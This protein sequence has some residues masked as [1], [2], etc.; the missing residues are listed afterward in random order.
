[1]YNTIIIGSGISGLFT[2]KHLLE[3]GIDNVLVLD[4]NPE[5]FG[6]WNRNNHPCVYETTYTVSSKLYMTIS[7][8]P[9]KDVAEFP[10]HSVIL[11]YYR[12]YAAHFNLYPYLHQNVTVQ[13]IY[14]NKTSWVVETHGN[15]YYCEHV[16]I[17]TGTVNDCPNIPTDDFYENFTGLKLHSDSFDEI[18]GVEGKNILIVGGSDTAV[19]S[20]IELK[21]K[22]KVTVS[23][24]NG[25]WFQSR[26]Q[27]AYEP[28][29]MFYSRTSDYLIKNVVTKK[30]VDDNT[31]PT[32][33]NNVQFWWGERGSGVDIW[34]SKCDYLNSYYVKSR[35]IIEH[36]S[37][38]AIIPENKITT[39]E[40]RK[41]TFE[42]GDT[43]TFDIILF[44]TGYTPL[45]CMRFL[46]DE[47]VQS[48]KYKKIFYP[49]DPTLMF[50][51][52]IR[53]YLTAIPMISELQ[54]RWVAQ[55]IRKKVTLPTKERMEREIRIDDKKQ[56]KEFPCAYDRL[57]TIIDPYDYANMVAY[58]IGANYSVLNL[59]F[60]DSALLH[61]VLFSS[62]NQMVYRL[63]DKDKDKRVIALESIHE[64]F[65]EKT[66]FKIRQF[67]YYNILLYCTY[68][69]LFILALLYF[70]PK[71]FLK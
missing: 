1:M 61:K 67:M 71:K 9:L 13:S 60:T 30:F 6:V 62:W 27:G 68:L 15:V 58:K 66:S 21:R 34:K 36:I 32:K 55:F 22:N 65:H 26:I 41:V 69:I 63:N 43:D 57:K 18:K 64:V 17:A 70:R 31:D 49:K 12:D 3:E 2:L 42:T 40:G 11:E 33:A 39:I 20:A 47:I 16:V 54:S 48:M 14:K 38:G 28:A 25:V 19:D 5:P 23:I 52:F 7:D 37:K 4:K 10:H 56:Q 53:P 29:D 24:K 50:V 44:C 45:K 35:E 8:F 51:G 46:D 59:L